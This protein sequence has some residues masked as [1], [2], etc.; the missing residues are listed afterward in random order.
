MDHHLK[1]PGE[2]MRRTWPLGLVDGVRVPA[3]LSPWIHT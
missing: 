3:A 1:T 2:E